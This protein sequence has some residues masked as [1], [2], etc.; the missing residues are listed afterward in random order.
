MRKKRGFTLLEMLTSL[1]IFA[2]VM[3]SMTLIFCSIVKD[4]Q[5][6]KYFTE[7]FTASRL[8]LD[9]MSGDLQLC[10]SDAV[11]A[12]DSG[13]GIPDGQVL[14]FEIDKVGSGLAGG[15]GAL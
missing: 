11:R 9:F 13:S 6:Q 5:N 7:S 15:H 3:S 4:W 8:A 12:H 10:E 2:L 14:Y 1:A